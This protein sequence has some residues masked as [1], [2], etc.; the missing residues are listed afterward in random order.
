MMNR[1]SEPKE[2]VG[3]LKDILSEFIAFKKGQGL[4]YCRPEYELSLF[5]KYTVEQGLTECSLPQWLLEPWCILRENETI[6]SQ[7]YRV[8]IINQ[9]A[10]YMH[11]H[12]Y[13]VCFPHK[14]GKIIR[15]YVPYIFSPQEVARILKAA[16]NFQ[17]KRGSRYNY[18]MPVVMRMLFGCGLR[19]SEATNLL[20]EDV[21]LEKDLLVIRESKNGKSRLIPM[22]RSLADVCRRYTELVDVSRQT[23]FF[24]MKN[25]MPPSTSTCYK[26]FRILL[27]QCGIAHEGRG[28]GP[29]LH[30]ARHTF[31]VWSLKNLADQKTDLYVALP[32]LSEYLG[33]H[34]IKE[35]ETY[36]RLTTSMFP[37]LILQIS[38]SSNY[39]IPEVQH[40]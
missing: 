30:D 5:S 19:I 10:V 3:P 7:S 11:G 40:E 32:I 8:S 17:L 29:R 14:T 21:D 16:D 12:D 39:V 34:S 13:E 22:D 25:H 31:A 38:T 36:V 20:V 18:I 24:E 37:D 9:L 35:T 33:H 26:L 15:R 1:K 23:Y 2:F 27:K 6:K 28:K 4:N